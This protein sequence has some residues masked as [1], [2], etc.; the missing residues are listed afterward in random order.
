MRKIF[1]VMGV[2]A[3]FATGFAANSSNVNVRAEVVDDLEIKTT[4]VDFGLVNRGNVDS[5]VT[6][7][8]LEINGEQNKSVKVEILYNDV[9]VTENNSVHLKNGT[10]VLEYR[11][12]LLQQ[13]T[14]VELENGKSVYLG[15][16]GQAKFDIEGTLNVPANAASGEHTGDMKIRVQYND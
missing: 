10:S 2:M 14:G 6:P 7:G 3:L 15:D 5:P 16:G 9:L 8:Y 1:L 12:K 11:P 13:G 4:D